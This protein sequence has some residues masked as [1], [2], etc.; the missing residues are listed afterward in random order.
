M[1]HD[2]DRKTWRKRGHGPDRGADGR[3]LP[4]HR[5]RFQPGNPGGPGRPRSSFGEYSREVDARS[6]AAFPWSRR[7]SKRLGLDPAE[8]TIGELMVHA[9][10][11]WALAGKV[12]YLVEDNNRREGKVPEHIRADVTFDLT[13]EQRRR[14]ERIAQKF[15][16][17]DL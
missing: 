14:A 4:G 12:G 16:A 9:T 2:D 1:A 10:K 17:V 3:L 5:Y 7:E 13:D 11:A 6:A 15:D 8:L